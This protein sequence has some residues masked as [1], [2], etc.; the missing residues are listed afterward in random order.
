M[1]Q[2]D[3]L[4]PAEIKTA[5][6]ALMPERGHAE[7]YQLLEAVA[8]Q[9][10]SSRSET[11]GGYQ[12]SRVIERYFGRVKRALDALAVE[13]TLVKVGAKERPPNGTSPGSVHYYTPEAFAAAK[14]AYEEREAAELAEKLRW[15]LVANRLDAVEV[16]LKRDGSLS[17][18]HWEHLL[19]AT[20]L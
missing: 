17:L 4:T 1:K 9:L 7:A 15:D 2:L 11:P 18:E 6:A 20:G 10:D 16:T 3:S 13:G 12:H 8:N 19:E 14:A 5:V